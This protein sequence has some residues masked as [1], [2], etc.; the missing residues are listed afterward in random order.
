M[1]EQKK[2]T[3]TIA[4]DFFNRMSIL[5]KKLKI[6]DYLLN[7]QNRTDNMVVGTH[8]AISEATGI[9]ASQVSYFMKKLEEKKIIKRHGQGVYEILIPFEEVIT[10]E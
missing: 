5:D 9:R 6:F 10:E 4:N 8:K 3:I 1:L 2:T 7:P